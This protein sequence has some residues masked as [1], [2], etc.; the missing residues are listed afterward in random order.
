MMFLSFFRSVFSAQQVS[1]ASGSG[2][3]DGD[4]EA[5]FSAREHP[6]RVSTNDDLSMGVCWLLPRR[7]VRLPARSPP[8]RSFS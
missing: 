6:E 5:L 1:L 2:N 4:D 7:I 3:G 8:A